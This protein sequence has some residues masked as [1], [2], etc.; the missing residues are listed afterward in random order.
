V[1]D[2]SEGSSSF[3][4]RFEGTLR[5]PA[6]YDGWCIGANATGSGGV[7]S[8][9]GWSTHSW[10]KHTPPAQ[11]HPRGGQ[12]CRGWK[13]RYGLISWINARTRAALTGANS[14]REAAGRLAYCSAVRGIVGGVVTCTAE[15]R[16]AR[17]IRFEARQYRRKLRNLSC[18]LERV[19]DD[20][21]KPSLPAR[22]SV[23]SGRPIS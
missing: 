12:P 9:P 6:V 15:S 16:G 23:K 14:D 21:Q 4:R 17:L 11:S 1:P 13:G 18:T 5:Q 20:G 22:N 3:H 10:I 2:L 8:R 7:D 19:M